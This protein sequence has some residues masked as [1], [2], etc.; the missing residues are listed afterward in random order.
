MT[1]KAMVFVSIFTILLL[2]SAANSFACSCPDDP[3]LTTEQKI[4]F[5]YKKAFLVFSGKVVEVKPNPSNKYQLI[6]KLETDKFWKGV[7]SKEIILSTAINGAGCGVLFEIGK[8]YLVYADQI[9]GEI[10]AHLCTRTKPL[11]NNKDI[12]F[13]DKLEILWKS[14]KPIKLYN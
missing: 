10:S 3:D 7:S 6:I 2:G 11:E 9:N 14:K 12:K 4:E 13:L 8:K 1:N 5:G